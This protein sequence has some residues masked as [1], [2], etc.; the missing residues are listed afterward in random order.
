MSRSADRSDGGDAPGRCVEGGHGETTFGHEGIGHPADEGC[1]GDEPVA[2]HPRDRVP[3]FS[4]A[5]EVSGLAE[6]E[7][8]VTMGTQMA[9]E[10]AQRRS[11]RF[12]APDAPRRADELGRPDEQLGVAAV[13]DEHAFTRS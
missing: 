2:V 8:D 12:D 13:D 11:G 10:P 7:L 9:G 6:H 5:S 3:T 1:V 4:R